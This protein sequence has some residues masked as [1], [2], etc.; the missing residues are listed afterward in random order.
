[1]ANKENKQKCNFPHAWIE[2][3]DRKN[4]RLKY[5]LSPGFQTK[6]IRK[7]N[8]YLSLSFS[9][10]DEADLV[11]ILSRAFQIVFSY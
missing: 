5:K 11:P 9:F 10:W 3:E 2:E 4:E 6:Y 7:K 8:L 1:M